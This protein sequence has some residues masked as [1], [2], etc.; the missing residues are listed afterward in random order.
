MR[1][2]RR[3]PVLRLG[4]VPLAAPSARQ[5][6]S[7]SCPPVGSPFEPSS[8]MLYQG[9]ASCELLGASGKDPLKRWKAKAS[10]GVK[11]LYDSG[12]RGYVYSIDGGAA[13]RL[14]LGDGAP[15]SSRGAHSL[16]LLHRYLVLQL[17][18]PPSDARPF[19]VELVVSDEK[20]NRRRVLLS[21]AFAAASRTPLHAQ[22]PLG[23]AFEGKRGKWLHWRVDVAGLAKV[24]FG[25]AVALHA[26]DGV[27]VGPSCR[28]RA[29]FT[30]RDAESPVPTSLALPA[31]VGYEEAVFPPDEAPGAAPEPSGPLGVFGTA[32]PRSEKAPPR[33]PT[34][35]IAFGHR[36]AKLAAPASRT[37][38]KRGVTVAANVPRVA[39]KPRDDDDADARP[40]TRKTPRAPTP[41]PPAQEEDEEAFEE[42][43]AFDDAPEDEDDEAFDDAP[44]DD[45]AFD[46]AP[47]GEDEDDGAPVAAARSLALR[48]SALA[49]LDDDD[50]PPPTPFRDSYEPL[51]DSFAANVAPKR[52]GTPFAK[53]LGTPFRDSDA[54]P[55]TPFARGAT[56]FH[57]SFADDT[58]AA[59]IDAPPVAAPGVDPSFLA[60]SVRESGA[61]LGRPETAKSFLVRESGASLCRPDT[62]E[63][64]R[65]RESAASLCRPATARSLRESVEP[66]RESAPSLRMSSV[67]PARESAT[68]LRMSS[69]P[70]TAAK[71]VRQSVEPARQSAT[72]LRSARPATA[73]KSVRQSVEPAR[74]STASLSRPATAKSVRQ[75]AEPARE[76]AASVRMS[77]RPATAAKSLRESVEPARESAASLRPATAKSLQIVE[78]ARQSTASLRVSSASIRESIVSVRESQTVVEIDARP[79]TARSERGSVP[80]PILEVPGTAD[81]DPMDFALPPSPAPPSERHPDFDPSDFAMPPSPVAPSEHDEFDPSD[82]AMPPS[83]A[84]PST[85]HSDFDPSDFAMPPSPAPPSERHPDFDPADFAMPLDEPADVLLDEPADALLDEP[86]PPTPA[87]PT[88]APP[89]P[90]PPPSRSRPASAATPEAAEPARLDSAPAARVGAD[91]DAAA[92]AA[93]GAARGRDHALLRRALKLAKLAAM[94]AS[95]AGEYGTLAS[96]QS[97]R[98]S[99]ASGL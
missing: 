83:P 20:K 80:A 57:D 55:A 11:R 46:D 53:P 6:L 69:R 26:L 89:T 36:C 39:L 34:V 87:P 29:V 38:D 63:S 64:V 4:K 10:G 51:R 84:P 60:Q 49:A 13:T 42:D 5:P 35:N 73:A 99:R 66:A 18:L 21:S 65:V 1:R 9:G 3:Y 22:L 91:R 67:E 14:A 92:A 61:T 50:E 45:E 19:A 68:S 47:L 40:P 15:R 2:G 81:F 33:N 8:M 82:F 95:Y 58:P 78:P 41:A 7:E 24:A 62:A 59:S 71:S 93:L 12:T 96:L 97:M 74:E 88:P 30:L 25:E 98:L 48:A 56:P 70:A 32:I 54:G 90:A 94:E 28:L 23:G 27:A 43:D 79:K 52:A 44:E 75:I 85:A 77:S 16:G 86:A 72:S 37:P 17:E 76:S 31:A